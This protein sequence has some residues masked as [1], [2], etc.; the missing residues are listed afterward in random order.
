MI[1]QDDLCLRACSKYIKR[2]H[3]KNKKTIFFDVGSNKGEWIDLVCGMLVDSVDYQVHAFEPNP[4]AYNLLSNKFSKADKNKVIL[5][6]TGVS[7]VAKTATLFD[8]KG[9]GSALGSLYDRE[10]FHS[11][12]DKPEIIRHQVSLTTLDSYVKTNNIDIINFLKIDVEGHE[13]EALEG[14]KVLFE[15]KQVNVGQ[16]EAG[17][18]FKDAGISIKDFIDF[19]NKYNYG[20][21]FKEVSKNCELKTNV[22]FE[23]ENILF[24]DKSLDSSL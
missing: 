10:V 22:E 6:N 20:I 12:A 7:S 5:N 18:T 16:F 15:N 3:G 13:I 21:Y 2:R 19:F 24:V 1:T 23:W 11:W 4:V 17:G 14:S 8:P 9:E